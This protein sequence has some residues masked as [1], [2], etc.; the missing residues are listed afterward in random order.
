MEFLRFIR[1]TMIDNHSYGFGDTDT[2]F[3]NNLIVSI[4]EK[5][6]FL[7]SES[8]VVFIIVMQ[9]YYIICNLARA[10]D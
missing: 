8:T 5:W 9:N 7:I 10:I 4:M 6:I 2:G 1:T 3:V